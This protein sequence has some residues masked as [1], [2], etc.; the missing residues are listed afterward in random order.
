MPRSLAPERMIGYVRVS[1]D[2]QAESGLGLASQERTV[3]QECRHR[4][5]HL[6]RLVRDEGLSAKTLE[7]PGLQLALRAI[8]DGQ[9]DGIIA[10]K[11][12]RLSRS[13]IDF[14]TLL[15]WAESAEATIV[16]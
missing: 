12:D 8:A 9:A 3:R 5:W 6:V 2:E 4:G 13:V 11:L 15:D 1:T 7:R 16:A 10:A 14:A